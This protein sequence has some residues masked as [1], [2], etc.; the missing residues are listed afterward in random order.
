MIVRVP[1]RRR[2]QYVQHLQAPPEA[3][4]PLLCPVREVDW[5][6][7]WMPD[8][9]I[10]HSGACEQDCVFVTPSEPSDAVWIVIRHDAAR[11]E[12]AMV[13]VV[14]DH[15]VTKLEIALAAES[16][17]TTE[18]IVSYEVTALGDLG[19]SFV[20]QFT[21]VFYERMMTEWESQLNHYLQT[22]RRLE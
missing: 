17:N 19:V 2:H 5:V 6:P 13:K 12:L 22:G 3:V 8:L 20:E 15:T 1:T 10:S 7:G 21:T 4:F 11:R 14:P 16:D 18:A 9:V